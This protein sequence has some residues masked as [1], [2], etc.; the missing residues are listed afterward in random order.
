MW[1]SRLGTPCNL[2]DASLIPGLGQW[3]KDPAFQQ[4]EAQLADMAPIQ[5]C[6]CHKLSAAAPFQ[7]LGWE[8]PY[9][10]GAVAKRIKIIEETLPLK[11]K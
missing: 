5:C 7:P 3:V 10:M 9:A 8:F 4:A 6:R 2:E 1:L 11:E